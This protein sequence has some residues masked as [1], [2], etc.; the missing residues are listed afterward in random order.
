IPGQTFSSRPI[1]GWSRYATPIANL[2]LCGAGTHPGGEVTG[3]PG[4]NAAQAILQKIQS[5]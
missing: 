3:A 4:H 5:I 2:Y 1:P